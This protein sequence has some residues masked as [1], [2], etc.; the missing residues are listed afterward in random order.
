MTMDARLS[1]LRR[2]RRRMPRLLLAGLAGLVLAGCENG[3]IN[4][5]DFASPMATAPVRMEAGPRPQ[6]DARGVISYP[7]YQVVAARQGDTVE[8][9]ATRIGLDPSE[10]ARFNGLSPTTGLRGGELLALPRRVETT[11]TDGRVD[12]AAIAGSAIERAPDAGGAERTREPAA[13]LGGEGE[14]VRHRVARGETAYSIARLYGVSVRS[15][16]DWNSLGSDLGVREGQFLLIPTAQNGGGGA[17]AAGAQA[18]VTRPGEGSPT[19]LPPSA[20]RPLPEGVEA[21]VI[22]DSPRLGGPTQQASRKFLRPVAGEIVRGF[23]DRAGGYE[24]IDIAAESGTAVKAAE[25]GEVALVSRSVNNRAIVLVSHP[26]NI[27]TVYSN[28]TDVSLEKGERVTRG[29]PIGK[30]APAAN[31]ARSFL[32]F[33]VRRGTEATDPM[34]F[35]E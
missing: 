26:G 9:V 24:G 13:A 33:Q 11:G 3:G 10:L 18:A 27:Y 15:L 35:L 21:A 32:H 14:P 12:I 28:I 34:P 5:R 2:N 23:S 31:G 7:S 1:N 30:V 22:P 4:L 16:A 6:P 29:Q 8:T 19:P 17:Q 20:S 25:A